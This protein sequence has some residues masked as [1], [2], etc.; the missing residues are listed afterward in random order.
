MNTDR[1]FP[2]VAFEYLPPV[3]GVVFVLGLIAAGYSSADGTLTALTTVLCVDF[4]GLDKMDK[5]EKG[6]IRIRRG[7]HV[8]M[9]FLFLAIILIFSRYHNE[10]L[11]RTLF[12]VAGYTYGPLLGLYTFGLFT[13]RIVTADYLVPFFACLSPLICFLLNMYSKQLFRGYEFGFEL[14]LV[15]GLLMFIFLFFVSRRVI[16][17]KK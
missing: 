3:A 9:G 1:I 11:I 2:T 17:N 6:K 7:I 16:G 15:N 8:L 5:S 10:A 4:I 12:M 13:K 14:L